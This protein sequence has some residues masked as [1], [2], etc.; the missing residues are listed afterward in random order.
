MNKIRFYFYKDS[1]MSAHRGIF[2]WHI[3]P[4]IDLFVC[5]GFNQGNYMKITIGWLLV[6]FEIYI[7][8]D[9]HEREIDDYE[10]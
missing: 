7:D 2:K 10:I 5:T 3:I 8:T 6:N 4:V 1:N 9:Y